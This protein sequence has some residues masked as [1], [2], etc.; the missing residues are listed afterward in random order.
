VAGTR[1]PSTDR[2]AVGRTGAR[3][4][5]GGKIDKIASNFVMQSKASIFS[6]N[7]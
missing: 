7:Y 1:S 4:P 5:T 2:L 3:A 6:K